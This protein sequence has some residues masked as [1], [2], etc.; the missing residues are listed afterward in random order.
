MNKSKLN[1]LWTNSDLITGEKLVLMYATNAL[2]QNWWDEV[3]I[4][5]WGVSAKLIDENDMLILFIILLPIIKP[6]LLSFNP[7]HKYFCLFI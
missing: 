1:I 5:V 2:L 3:E 7:L 6:K 4:I